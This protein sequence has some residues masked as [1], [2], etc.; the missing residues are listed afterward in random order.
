ME[1]QQ[2]D[3]DTGKLKTSIKTR[4]S[5]TMPALMWDRTCASV[6]KGQ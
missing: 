1:Q 6:V 3:D 5:T 2:K 4:N